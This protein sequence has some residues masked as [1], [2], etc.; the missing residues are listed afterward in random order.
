M[1][2]KSAATHLGPLFFEQ[3]LALDQFVVCARASSFFA[4]FQSVGGGE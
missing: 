4:I 2:E 1:E 3:H